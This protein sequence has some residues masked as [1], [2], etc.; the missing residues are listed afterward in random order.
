MSLL[1]CAS[2]RVSR[3]KDTIVEDVS[4]SVEPG[5]LVVIV[6]PNGAGKS[7]LLRALAGLLPAEG[8][9]LLGGA[10]LQELAPAERAKRIAYVPQRT[11][12]R[13]LL[14]V[15]EVIAQGRYAHRGG[16]K[17]RIATA[18]QEAGADA[19]AGRL[20][21]ELS[22]GEQ[23]RVLI[24]RAL[25]TEAPLL[26]LDEPTAALD[27]LQA[28]RTH[29][30]FRRLADEGRGLVIVLHH[31]DD[32]LRFADRC[33]LLGAGRPAKVVASGSPAEVIAPEPLRDVYGVRFERSGLRFFEAE[34]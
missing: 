4:F 23:Q 16:G 3:G 34:Q 6:G 14:R 32:A 13:A 1:H 5:E 30:L 9:I 33:L 20:F 21:P 15:E 2:L 12:L 7:T 29:R 22:I 28:L 8:D 27:A 25:A 11:Q 18:M 31:L 17:G 24:A 26:L 10:R 19:F